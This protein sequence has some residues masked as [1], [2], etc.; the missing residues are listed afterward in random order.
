M[1]CASHVVVGTSYYLNVLVGVPPVMTKTSFEEVLED[2]LRQ[3]I[4]AVDRVADEIQNLG[5]SEPL[6]VS[7][8]DFRI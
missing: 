1:A 8:T 2:L 6:E 5:I 7:V 3:L 4:N